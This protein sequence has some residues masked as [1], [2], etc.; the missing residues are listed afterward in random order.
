MKSNISGEA[1]ES[2]MHGTY[3]VVSAWFETCALPETWRSTTPRR[4]DIPKEVE[5]R[6]ESAVT[7]ESQS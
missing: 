4:R 7:G 2:Q 3:S 1:L 5:F 6:E